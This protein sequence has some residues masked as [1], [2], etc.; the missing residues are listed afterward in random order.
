MI[1]LENVSFKYKS[2]TEILK[3]IN[4]QISKGECISIIGKNGARKV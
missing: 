4:I 3:N 2:N 1:R